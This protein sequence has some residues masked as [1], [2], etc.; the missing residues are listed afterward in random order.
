VLRQLGQQPAMNAPEAVIREEREV[1][2]EGVKTQ[3]NG[4][5]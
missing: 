1:V 4:C 3:S 2:M 5:E